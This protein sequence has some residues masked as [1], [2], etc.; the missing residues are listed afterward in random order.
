MPTITK[1]YE[2]YK[3]LP[4]LQEH[5]LRVAAV[6]KQIC[7]NLTVDVNS[8]VVV[9]ACLIH[10]MANILKF[11][12]ARPISIEAL[13]PGGR[14]YWESVKQEFRQ[15]YGQD[16]H[17]ATLQIAKELGVSYA[18]L[19]CIDSIAWS[20]AKANAA[21]G[22]MEI[23]ICDYADT[24]VDPYGI[25]SLDERIEEGWKRYKDHKTKPMT[26]AMFDE[27]ATAARVMERQIFADAKIKSADI[28]NESV[29]P[30]ID[31][32]KTYKI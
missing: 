26:R 25:V 12:L 5:Q 30:I 3:I 7:D 6:A 9:K 29:A 28:T 21:H 24:R 18:V 22:S 14:A 19:E 20:K 2:R 10:D 8:E 23:K 1:L 17:L 32:L 27:L 13:E 16:E 11:D 15:K 31:K 4:N